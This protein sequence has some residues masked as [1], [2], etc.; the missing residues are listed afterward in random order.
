MIQVIAY[1]DYFDS[2]EQTWKISQSIKAATPYNNVSEM[3]QNLDKVLAEIPSEEHY[4]LHYTIANCFEAPRQFKSQTLIPIDVDDIKEG[5][6]LDEY[7]AII[8]ETLNIPFNEFIQ[9]SSGH[10]LHILLESDHTLESQDELKEFQPAYKRL[11]ELLDASF[12][13][14]GL[15]GKTDPKIYRPSGTL[16]LPGTINRC[17]KKEVI[18]YP[19]TNCTLLNSSY[20]VQSFSSLLGERMLQESGG[21]LDST[22]IRSFPVP[23]SE[24]VIKECRF[25]DHAF[26]SPEKISEPE[27][28]AALSIVGHLEDGNRLA[29]TMS[30]GHPQYTHR[31]TESKLSQ[32]MAS[33]GPRTCQNIDTVSDKCQSC[34]HFGKITSP[35]LLKGP[36]YI[37]TQGQ[38]FWIIAPDRSGNPKPIRPAYEDLRRYFEK[39]F[40]YVSTS[41]RQ[42]WVWDSPVWKELKK[43]FV[44]EFAQEHLNPKPSSGHVAEFVNLI[45][46]TNVVNDDWFDTMSESKVNLSNGVLDMQSLEFSSH[47]KKYGFKFVLGHNYDPAATSPRF[48]KFMEEITRGR[49]ELQDVLMEYMAYC[50]SGMPYIYHKCLMLTGEGSNGK[51]VFLSVLKNLAGFNA[52]SSLLV[53][54]FEDQYYRALMIGKL[55]NVGEETPS[56]KLD[57]SFFKILSSGG[58][59]QARQPYGMPVQVASNKTKLIMACNDLPEMTDFSEGFMRRL[60][61]VPFDAKFTDANADSRIDDKLKSELPGIFN[62]VIEAY[63][64]LNGQNGFTK[65]E[66]I[67]EAVATYRQEQNS[68]VSFVEMK[69][70]VDESRTVSC[71]EFVRSYNQWCKDMGIKP[72]TPNKVGRDLGRFFNIKSY[73]VKKDGRSL[74]NYP[75]VELANAAGFLD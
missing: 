32:A 55:F 31:D 41:S 42:V 62:R 50:M 4:N 64:R 3:L 69:C 22:S 72:E 28:Y 45:L 44:E 16:R 43:S 10:G 1:R 60:I 33:S 27:W 5:E 35:I 57:S 75:G 71:E 23:D 73:F 36:N 19:D 39:R 37:S 21:A 14:A 7:I 63:K 53:N 59:F 68:V 13:A 25:I 8:S 17:F 74:R 70:I 15:V 61:I 12:R 20:A 46:R 65:S 6:S 29:H 58:S 18:Q 52:Y 54:Q 34:P 56:R 30:K 51:S 48:D 24:Y 9:V 40:Q 67:K 47:D 2:R 11:C 49:K 38:G 26:T 66:I